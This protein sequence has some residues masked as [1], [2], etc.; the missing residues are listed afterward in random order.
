M[1]FRGHGGG[2]KR[3]NFKFMENVANSPTNSQ[4]DI[5]LFVPTGEAGVT[6]DRIIF[7]GAVAGVAATENASINVGVLIVHHRPD[8][9]GAMSVSN[10]APMWP[11]EAAVLFSALFPCNEVFNAPN[12]ALQVDVKGQRILKPG[13]E[14]RMITLASGASTDLRVTGAV[15]IFGK[16]A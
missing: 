6:V 3:R 1:T 13:D 4:A 8:S 14:I 2:S 5:P 7:T 11:N 9:L 12:Y 16:L 10:A 15:T